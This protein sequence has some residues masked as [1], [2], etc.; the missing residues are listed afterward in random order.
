MEYRIEVIKSERYCYFNA[1][2]GSSTDR[3]GKLAVEYMGDKKGKIIYVITNPSHI[4]KGVATALM[5][6]AIEE[7]KDYEL[8]LNVIP[9]PRKCES[10]NHR[11]VRGLTNFYEKFG[12]ERISEPCVPTMIRKVIQKE[13]LGTAT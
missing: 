10:I 13:T 11:T 4:G 7:F 8:S 6:K 9:M 12:F 5:N 2:I 3:I 1:Y